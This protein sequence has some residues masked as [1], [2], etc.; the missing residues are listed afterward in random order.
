MNELEQRYRDETRQSPYRFIND[1][2]YD[3]AIETVIYNPV[4]VYNEGYVRWLEAQITIKIEPR[5]EE[6][7]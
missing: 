3:R 6:E 1:Q 7:L 4:K 2:V 5:G